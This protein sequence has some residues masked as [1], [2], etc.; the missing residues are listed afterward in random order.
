VGLAEPTKFVHP[1]PKLWRFLAISFERGRF[2]R[3]EAL[4]LLDARARVLGEV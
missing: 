1:P 3:I 2:L 4:D